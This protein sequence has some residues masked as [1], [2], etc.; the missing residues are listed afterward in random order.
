MIDFMSA[1]KQ[2][3]LMVVQQ[4]K[5]QPHE[6]QTNPAVIHPH[7]HIVRPMHLS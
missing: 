4:H 3:S 5:L 6:E 1:V 2:L 7:A